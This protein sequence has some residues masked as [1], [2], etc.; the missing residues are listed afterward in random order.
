MTI[1]IATISNLHCGMPTLTVLLKMEFTSFKVLKS[2][3]FQGIYLTTTASTVI[4]ESEA[5][6]EI[7]EVQTTTTFENALFDSHFCKKCK[8]KPQQIGIF[9][10]C[11]NCS[12]IS[13]VKNSES[14]FLF[15][16]SFT[17]ENDTKVMLTMPHEVL[18]F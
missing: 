8:R 14:R 5:E 12:S 17:K 2:E 4:K 18:G 16:A 11:S 13:L 7:K 10:I 1:H 6:I 3:Q 15:K 9:A